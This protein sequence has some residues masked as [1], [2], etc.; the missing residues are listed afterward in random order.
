[1]E[2]LSRGGVHSTSVE[3][4]STGGGGTPPKWNIYPERGGT[5]PQWNIY[6]EGGCT[7]PH[8]N[9]F[10]QGGGRY[11]TSVEYLCTGGGGTPPQWNIYPKGGGTPP[12]W[13]IYPEG[14]GTPP[15]WNIYAEGGCTATQWNIYPHGGGGYTTSVEYFSRPP[16]FPNAPFFHPF[17]SLGG[18][19]AVP[20]CCMVSHSSQLS[21]FMMVFFLV[22]GCVGGGG[23][24]RL[25]LVPFFEEGR[26][27]GIGYHTFIRLLLRC[28]LFYVLDT[29]CQIRLQTSDL[30]HIAASLAFSLALSPPLPT[31]H[32]PSL[33]PL[34][35]VPLPLGL[36]Q[37][38]GLDSDVDL[39]SMPTDEEGDTG[40]DR[41]LSESDGDAV[42]SPAMSDD[43]CTPRESLRSMQANALTT[44]NG[45]PQVEYPW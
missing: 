8:W 14:G 36:M 20:L 44:P 35:H 25:F 27:G 6:P 40:D 13:N 1:M 22:G 3:H 12:K 37:L 28:V 30:I 18:G 21:I 23:G 9:I 42:L 39:D 34:H 45:E 17:F 26:K 2:Y 11:T 16:I 7:A 24:G 33:L 43:N 41:G 38:D 10:P 19:G 29:R 5:P 31:N 15:Q 4:F 32:P